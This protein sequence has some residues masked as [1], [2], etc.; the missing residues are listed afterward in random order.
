MDL[1]PHLSFVL[2]LNND[3]SVGPLGT[4]ICFDGMFK[5]G[6]MFKPFEQEPTIQF[7]MIAGRLFLFLFFCSVPSQFQIN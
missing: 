7:T 2:L 3:G 4:I 5:F 6:G 1:D